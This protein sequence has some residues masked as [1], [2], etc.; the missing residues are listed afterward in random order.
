MPLVSSFFLIQSPKLRRIKTK[1]SRINIKIA[2][3]DFKILFGFIS[4]HHLKTD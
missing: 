4:P 3:T 1:S 2:L